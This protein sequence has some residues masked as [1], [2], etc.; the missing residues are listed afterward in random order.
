MSN[1]S[2]ELTGK[3]EMKL[4]IYDNESLVCTHIVND[5]NKADRI[6]EAYLNLGLNVI[7]EELRGIQ[8]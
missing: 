2:Q 6:A 5:K 4:F 3:L 7:S 8:S 1:Q